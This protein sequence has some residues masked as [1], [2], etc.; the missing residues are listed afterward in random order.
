MLHK[1]VIQAGDTTS[2]TPG[3]PTLDVVVISLTSATERR[4]CITE[5]FSTLPRA[6][7]FFDAHASLQHPDLQYDAE[8]VRRSFGRTLSPQELAVWSSHYS[9]VTRFLET[10]ESDYL[11]VFEDDVIFDTAF[12]LSTVLGLCRDRD[13]H[14]LRLF[15]MYDTPS[16]RL[17]F[18]F[19]RSVIRYRSSPSGLQAYVL[20]RKGAR[21]LVTTRRRIE[22]AVD[23]AFDQFWKTGLP[24]Y[25]IFPFPTI[26]RFSPSTNVI[27]PDDATRP[28]ERLV[29]TGH[30]LRRRLQKTLANLR[31]SASDRRFRRSALAFQQVDTEH[32][33][34]T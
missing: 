10:S 11:L 24:I 26:E 20:S 7:S 2:P 18:F 21:R 13:L 25:A 8:D 27:P 23:L 12:P 9:V 17:S 31:L 30:R 34:G 4:R 15:G 33:E 29:L 5:L 14:Y 32:L 6:W 28:L 19:D 1:P 16:K 22:T 3:A